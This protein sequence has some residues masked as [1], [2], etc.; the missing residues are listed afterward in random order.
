MFVYMTLME[1]YGLFSDFQHPK[2]ENSVGGYYHPYW[3]SA[4]VVNGLKS[5]GNYVYHQQSHL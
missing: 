1:F 5:G 3:N 2:T 4:R